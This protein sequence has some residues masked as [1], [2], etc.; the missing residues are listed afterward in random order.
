ME[1]RKAAAEVCILDDLFVRH[2]EVVERLH[3]PYR[4]DRMVAVV[5]FE[6][7]WSVVERQDLVN[8]C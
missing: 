5:T 2:D 7:K 3:R 1:R 6:A 8:G 4:V